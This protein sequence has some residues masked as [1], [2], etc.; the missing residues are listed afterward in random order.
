[1]GKLPVRRWMYLENES[2]SS[3][4]TKEQDQ[5]NWLLQQPNVL[6]TPH[7]AGYTHES[8]FKMSKFLADKLGI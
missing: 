2:L 3:Y 7:I 6:V 5:L 8:F 4:S 1:M